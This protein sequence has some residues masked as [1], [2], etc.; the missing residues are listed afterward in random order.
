MVNEELINEMTS[1]SI[2]HLK[3]DRDSVSRT[4]YSLAL[5]CIN[6]YSG[7]ISSNKTLKV[8]LGILH[9]LAGDS[10]PI[11]Q[12]WALHALWLTIEAAGLNF[13]SYVNQTLNLVL[14]L[15]CSDSHRSSEVHQCLGRII[16]ALISTI[17]PELQ[18][19]SNFREMCLVFCEILKTDDFELVQ[20][21]ALDCMQHMMLFTPKHID[22]PS[23]LPYLE[24]KLSSRHFFMRNASV[25]C[26]KQL[27]QREPELVSAHGDAIEETLF[28]MLD[29]ES[30]AEII[31]RVKALL[32]NLLRAL[33]PSN[34]G[35][36]LSV[37]KSVLSGP[38]KA[39][40][41]VKAIQE[42]DDDDDANE[43]VV[44]DNDGGQDAKPSKALDAGWKTKEFAVECVRKLIDDC[45]L[46]SPVHFDLVQVREMKDTQDSSKFLVSHLSELIPT[47]FNAATSGVDQL[48]L[49]GL[50]SLQ[51]IIEKFSQAR[52]PDFL[53]SA[54]LEQY[55]AQFSAALR[56]AFSM[57]T[58]PTIM[59]K[60]CT[61]CGIWMSSGVSK[62]QSDLKRVQQLIVSLLD[63]IQ[64]NS[65]SAYNECAVTIVR[66]S[67][68]SAWSQLY[69]TYRED[70]TA[71]YLKDV[72]EPYLPQLYEQW[73]NV[74]RDY[75]LIC[76]PS[77]YSSRGASIGTYFKPWAK[78]RVKKNYEEVWMNIT[79][80]SA[81]LTDTEFGHH[82]D[83]SKVSDMQDTGLVVND[84][85]FIM[86]GLCMRSLS[87]RISS[88]DASVVLRIIKIN[89]SPTSLY[90]YESKEDLQPQT[91]KIRN[92]L[93]RQ[94]F[95][96]FLLVF[97]RLIQTQEIPV[98]NMA[99][100]ILLELIRN[101]H[102]LDPVTEGCEITAGKSPTYIL[103]EIC[104]CV[105]LRYFPS[106]NPQTKTKSGPSKLNQDMIILLSTALTV[107]SLIPSASHDQMCIQVSPSVLMLLTGM[108]RE[109]TLELGNVIVRSFSN[110]FGVQSK[111]FDK[112]TSEA[113]NKIVLCTL[114]SICDIL[115]D[116]EKQPI[117]TVNLKPVI[118]SFAVTASA[119][120]VSG[121]KNSLMRRSLA[122][123]QKL[124]CRPEA[125]IRLVVAQSLS[126]ILQSP[127]LV[128]AVPFV[129]E[130]A[131]S[132]V[133]EVHKASKTLP[134]KEEDIL[135]VLEGISVMEKLVS[136]SNDR[137]KIIGLQ[138]P[139]LIN[140]LAI[141]ETDVAKRLH[142]AALT[143]LTKIGPLY[144][145]EFKSVV[146]NA[147]ADLKK[148]LENA[149]REN[150]SK[151][152]VSVSQP[153]GTHKKKAS[154]SKPA[155]PSIQLRTDFSNF[156]LS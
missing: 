155:A 16:H 32:T 123:M 145:Q 17:G 77:P 144:P 146:G 8:T 114:G 88:A 82:L 94:V 29:S 90:V 85:F 60:A 54:L 118:L 156:G 50:T 51:H 55:Q 47:A 119:A 43:L 10:T 38:K 27:V 149:I 5:G 106:L 92:P 69:V 143:S 84:D 59:A 63:N 128:T 89:F 147:P 58:S 57:E 76:L 73:L 11:V 22:L 15:L 6:R 56:P 78:D 153:R 70:K 23:F 134:E 117:K 138:V 46:E 80:A 98:Q 95:L 26:L 66:L 141:A 48:R 105:L 7:G 39:K 101:A 33:G 24:K 18:V 35:K 112:N 49:V 96:E 9:A 79:L 137:E 135:A 140:L 2:E 1:I 13:S 64:E 125:G 142:Q 120:K 86:L 113:W 81:L 42:A 121:S 126:C 31:E 110:V 68:L 108:L 34:P 45:A 14:N 65:F 103:I 30:D 40:E 100:S 111:D 150:A 115:E 154:E 116:F 132:I 74:V 61:V 131:P 107:L 122:V 148:K 71:G 133:L 104:V 91:S 3:T 52:D 72:I 87:R 28:K 97:H 102:E 99:V 4:G 36:W 53:E 21:S 62:E 75:A 124:F 139:L 19:N 67:L 44:K 130:L 151:G 83:T 20:L 129:H 37:C 93:P 109:G 25:S 12:L 136:L 41:H 152:K 127:N